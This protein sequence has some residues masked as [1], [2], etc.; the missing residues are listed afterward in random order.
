MRSL[1]QRTPTFTLL[2][3]LT[4]IASESRLNLY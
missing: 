3:A 4:Y 1:E 2:V